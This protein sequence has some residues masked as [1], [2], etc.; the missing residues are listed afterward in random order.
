MSDFNGSQKRFEEF[1]KSNLSGGSYGHARAQ[2]HSAV[3]K[4]S[5]KMLNA[6]AMWLIQVK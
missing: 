2:L 3:S 6:V 1:G 5:D 4:A